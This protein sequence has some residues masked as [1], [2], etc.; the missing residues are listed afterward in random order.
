M[1]TTTKNVKPET[2][3][4]IQASRQGQLDN[5]LAIHGWGLEC[6]GNIESRRDG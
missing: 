4:E 5:S 6:G 2:H 3:H 1:M